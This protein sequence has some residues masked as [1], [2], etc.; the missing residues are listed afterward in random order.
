MYKTMF[1]DRNVKWA[2]WVGRRLEKPG[3]VFM[4]VGAGHL[5]G[6]DSVQSFLAKK[7]ISAA[8]VN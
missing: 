3:I 5:A 8:K 7:G 6:K 4:A 1:A 2:D